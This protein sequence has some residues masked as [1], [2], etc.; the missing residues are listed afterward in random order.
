MTI[1]IELFY[2][3]EWGREECF[4]FRKFNSFPLKSHSLELLSQTTV[5]SS[6]LQYGPH[7]FGGGKGSGGFDLGL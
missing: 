7:T 3:K 6:A 1:L 4:A 2:S 5:I